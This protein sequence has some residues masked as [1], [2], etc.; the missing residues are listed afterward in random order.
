MDEK[1]KFSQQHMVGFAIIAAY[2]ISVV[3]TFPCTFSILTVA[4]A[5]SDSNKDILPKRISECVSVGIIKL[6]RQ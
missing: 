1:A 3:N 4:P 2:R 5:F 6:E